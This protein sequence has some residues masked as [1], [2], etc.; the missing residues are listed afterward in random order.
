[1]SSKRYCLQEELSWGICNLFGSRDTS[2]VSGRGK[3]APSPGLS[4]SLDTSFSVQ[5]FSQS[6]FGSGLSPS[7]KE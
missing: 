3:R 7:V 5:S 6:V 1:M 4:P 2:E